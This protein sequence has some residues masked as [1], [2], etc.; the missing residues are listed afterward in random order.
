MTTQVKTETEQVV[1]GSQ[2]Y[3]VERFWGQLPDGI[4]LGIV[5]T[6]AVDSNGTVFVAQRGGAPVIVFEANGIFREQWDQQGVTDPHGINIDHR[7]RVLLVDRDAHEIQLYS[8]SGE[9]LSTLGTRHYPRFQA[10]FNHPTS[11]FATLDGEIYVADGYGNAAVHRFASDGTHLA[12]WG[13]PG[14]GPGEFSTPHSVWVDQRNRVLVADRE[15]DRICVFDRGGEY[16]TSWSGFYHP[17]DICE[18]SDGAITS[19]IR[20][21]A[22]T[23]STPTGRLLAVPDRFER[24]SWHGLFTQWHDLLRRHEAQF[25][26]RNETNRP[27]MP[28][29]P[30]RINT[31]RLLDRIQAMAAVGA[32]DGG[33]V[34]R[35]ALSQADADAR[36]L[37]V[38]WMKDLQLTVTVDAIGNIVGTRAGSTGG[39]AVMTGSHIDSVATG[40]RYDGTLGVLAGLEVIA[41]LNELQLQT[42]RP[43]A[44]GSFTNEEGARFAPDM[45]GSAVHQGELAL[46]EALNTVDFNGIR[47]GDCLQQI[48]YAG[49]VPVPGA[50]PYAFVEL[51]IEQGPVLER[52]GVTIGAVDSVQGISWTEYTVSGVSN[53]AGTTPMSMR[54]DAGYAAAKLAV[55]AREIASEI[56]GAQVCTVGAINLEPNLVNVVARRAVATV[57]MRNVDETVLKRAE[58]MMTAAVKAIEASEGVTISAR[59]LARFAPVAFAPD[60]VERVRYWAQSL[61]F[62]VKQMPSGAGHDA[63]MFAPSCPTGMIFIPSRDGISHN[64]REYSA[65][66][67][68][69]AGANILV[70]LLI[71]LA[72]KE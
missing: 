57:D 8:A 11:A 3:A 29:D 50:K 53:H 43:L 61:G 62:T 10:P 72:N 19:V 27:L 35:L 48:G 71:E 21:P 37:L 54:H 56:G 67:D 36:N 32:I 68:I 7:D 52:E 1:L 23:N 12:T 16:V 33:G 34:N 47:L 42:A 59:P 41:T 18:D 38:K 46:E 9:R 40:G 65:P 2:R 26:Y 58:A 22:Y 30:I 25:N 4:S 28:G 49:S 6:I 5:S 13:K 64:V 51:H 60:I 70:N 69:E 45:L 63:Q 55:S 39:A 66:A 17:M 14:T 24:T 44:V 20:R 15:N 31:A